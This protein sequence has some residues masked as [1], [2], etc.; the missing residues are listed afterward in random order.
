MWLV[1]GFYIKFGLLDSVSV[2]QDILELMSGKLNHKRHSKNCSCQN[3]QLLGQDNWNNLVS[4]LFSLMI[5]VN[6]TILFPL[7]HCIKVL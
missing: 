5:G 4:I 2:R 1:L 6:E 7:H 3:A